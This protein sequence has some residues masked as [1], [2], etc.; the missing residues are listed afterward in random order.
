[1]TANTNYPDNITA[2]Y[3]RLSQEDALDGESNSI[4]NQ[5][6]ILLKYATDNHFS[7]PTFFIDDGVSGVTFDRP[8]WNEMIRLAEAGKV[9]TVIVKDMSRMGRDY[10]KVGYYTESFFAERDIRYIAINDGVDSDKGDNDFTPFRNLFNDFYARDTSKKIR[11]VMRA[12]GNAG[13]HLCT[14]P[15]YGYMKDPADKKKWMVDEEAAEIVKRIFDLCIA[16]KGPMQIAK[17]L[18]AEHILTVKAHYAQRAGKPLPEK[19]YHWDPK[20]VAGILERPEYTG[21]TVNFKT[22]SKSHK[23][24]KRLY[25][26]P[27]N[28]RIFPNTQPAIIDEQVFVRVQE[29]RENKRRPAKQAERQGLFSGLLYCADCGSKLHFATGKNMTPQ[30][31][32]Y[33]CSRYKSNTGDCTMHFIREET[34]KLFVLQRIFDVTALFFD[35]AM[36]FEEA[37]KKQHFQEAEKEA[38][39]RKREIAQAEKRI[40]ELDRIFKRIYEDDISGTISHERFLKLS[41]DYEAEQRELTEQVKTW[42]EVVEIFEQDRSD[43]DS[44]AAIVR[45]YVGIRELTPTIVNE[46]VKKIIVHAP[47][48]SSGHRRQKIELVWNFI[49]EVNLPGDDQTVERQRKGRTA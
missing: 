42:R 44:F 36:A 33:R 48:K 30:Q 3:A 16:G 1:M 43:F 23:L 37:A 4:A 19:P 15:P 29:L 47:D 7:N 26:V 25:N 8:G 21:C 11:A 46:F 35:D 22:Y 18:T 45:K 2:L 17:L 5:K 34:L 27:E 12:K 41:T 38:Q 24:K 32:C 6:K 10:L 39:K 28:Q 9:Q 40:A 13:E 14:N 20:S 49:G 31:D